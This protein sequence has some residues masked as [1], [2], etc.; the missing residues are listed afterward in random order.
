MEYFKL[1]II[2]K[3]FY[4]KKQQQNT[5]RWNNGV[6]L[7]FLTFCCFQ[8]RISDMECSET[9]VICPHF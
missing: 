9:C 3:K 6:V 4:L 2:D 8:A 7:L 5:E 1:K